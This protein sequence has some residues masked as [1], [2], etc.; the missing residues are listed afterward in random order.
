MLALQ[1]LK[2]MNTKQVR[3]HLVSNYDAN[4]KEVNQ[5][6]ILIAYESVGSWGCDSSSYFLLEH[7]KDKKLYVVEGSH[8]SCFGFENQF[9]PSET[10]V[11]ALKMW[12]NAG[13]MY[14]TGGY[15]D[16]ADVNVKEVKEFISKL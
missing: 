2:E 13:H 16:N 10:S 4:L 8:C 12:A 6:R 11:E 9:E 1:D 3:A 5:F 7:K 14:F 15:D